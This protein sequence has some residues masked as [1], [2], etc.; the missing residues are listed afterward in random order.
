MK[1]GLSIWDSQI[2]TAVSH[3]YEARVIDMWHRNFTGIPHG[4]EERVIDMGQPDFN[5]CISRIWSKGYRYVT[6][7]FYWCISLQEN[8]E[9]QSLRVTFLPALQF[10]LSYNVTYIH[11]LIKRHET[12]KNKRNG[13]YYRLTSDCEK[14]V[15]RLELNVVPNWKSEF[16][17]HTS[18]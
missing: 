8:D 18:F 9:S 6:S 15:K 16:A 3:E 4:Y 5:C 14:N 12:C 13:G 11:T 7:I 2:L 17:V 1:Q 10:H